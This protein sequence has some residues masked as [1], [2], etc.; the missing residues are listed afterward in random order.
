MKKIFFLFLATY[1]L[2]SHTKSHIV[3]LIST[4]RACSTIFTHM[5]YAR[6]DYTIINEPGIGTYFAIFHPLIVYQAFPKDIPTHFSQIQSMILDTSSSQGNLFIKEMGYAAYHYLN[7]QEFLNKQDCSIIFLL[8]NPHHSLISFY[9]KLN[10]FSKATPKMFDYQKLY[11]LYHDLTIKTG[12]KPLIVIA[13]ELTRN[14]KQNIQTICNYLDI[15]FNEN[16]LSWNSLDTN[17]SIAKEWHMQMQTNVAFNWYD[18]ALKT[19]H[20]ESKTYAY[21]FDNNGEPTFEEIEDPT[22]RQ[23]YKNLYTEIMPYYE[24]LLNEYKK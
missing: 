10:T 8:R 7:D 12:K 11:E 17:F 16:N 22:H 23:G 21:A 5:M 9:K 6:G 15:S 14:P 3:Y 4:P 19:T 2:T 18:E 24:L 20:L 1:S 13:E